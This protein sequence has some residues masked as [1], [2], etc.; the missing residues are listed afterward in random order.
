[1]FGDVGFDCVTEDKRVCE[2]PC[3]LY[4]LT[5]LASA[6]GGDVTL[7]E[8]QDASSGRKIG[9]YKGAANVTNPIMFSFP[10]PLARGLYVDIGSSITEVTVHFAQQGR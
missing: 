3:D 1:M 6:A 2:G 5:V 10:L 8:G 9:T 7:Y 4:G